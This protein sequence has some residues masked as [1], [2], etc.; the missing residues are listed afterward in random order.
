MVHFLRD[1]DNHTIISCDVSKTDLR[2]SVNVRYYTSE[3]LKQ[4]AYSVISGSEFALNIDYLSELRGVWWEKEEDNPKW[5]NI[6]EFV[7]TEYK[8]VAEKFK[9][10]YVTD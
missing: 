2:S 4:G 9:L 1:K 5:K 6:D 8:I 3:F 10:N 7:A